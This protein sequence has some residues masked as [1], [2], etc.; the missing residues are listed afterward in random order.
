MR[1]GF[2]NIWK[3]ITHWAQVN[4]LR[5]DKDIE[6]RFKG[7]LSGKCLGTPFMRVSGTANQY[8]SK[9]G[10]LYEKNSAGTL[11]R[12]NHDGTRQKRRG[13]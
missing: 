3:S 11:F 4:S 5:P 9:D 1:K 2:L 13:N 8:Q 10:Q 6:P 12:I 7:L